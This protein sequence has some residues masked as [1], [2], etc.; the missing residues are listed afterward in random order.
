MR[1]SPEHHRDI[2]AAQ[3]RASTESDTDIF[4]CRPHGLTLTQG[5]RLAGG[6]SAVL[7]L[8]QVFLVS[9]MSA[10]FWNNLI[11]AQLIV[12]GYMRYKTYLFLY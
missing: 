7:K 5:E 2:P 3:A 10:D 1:R 12:I 6:P 8:Q 11:H 9:S 4:M